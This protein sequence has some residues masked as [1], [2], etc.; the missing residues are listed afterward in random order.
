[1][2]EVILPGTKTSESEFQGGL[3]GACGPNAVAA[4]MRW[5]MKSIY[6]DTVLVTRELQHIV[7]SPNGVSDLGE[8]E[9][10]AQNMGFYTKIIP[11]ATDPFNGHVMPGPIVAYI[12]FGAKLQDTIFHDRED[13]GPNLHGHFIT[14][15]GYNTGGYSATFGRTVPPGFICADGDSNRVNPYYNGNIHH[16]GITDILVYYSLDDLKLAQ[17]GGGLIITA[18]NGEKPVIPE[19]WTDS[20][21][22]NT[23]DFNGVLTSPVNPRTGKRYNVERGF[24]QYVLS[25]PGGWESWNLPEEDEVYLNPLEESNPE[26]SYGSRQCFRTRVLEYTPSRGVFVGWCGQ[27]LAV[28]RP[29]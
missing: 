27:E 24:R 21:N 7:Y 14:L 28:L 9:R 4:A 16:Y 29:W 15:Y 26:L 23:A 12:G 25:Y 1:M 2:S 18:K 10:V 11:Y 5:A 22:G 8:L 17:V 3:T 20:A 19:G 6:P 13:A